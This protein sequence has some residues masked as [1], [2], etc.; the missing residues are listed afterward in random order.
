MCNEKIK[1]ANFDGKSPEWL[2]GYY[3]GVNDCRENDMFA[4][5]P[6][7]AA[8]PEPYILVLVSIDDDIWF[9]Y[10]DCDGKW[11]GD[12]SK[13]EITR[14]ITAWMPLP[15]PYSKENEVDHGRI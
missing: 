8:M 14:E 12:A 5:N 13:S 11:I 9:A 6:V 10:M 1:P 3:H 2:D 4:W 7:S 15:E